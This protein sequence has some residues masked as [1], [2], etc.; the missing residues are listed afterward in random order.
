VNTPKYQIAYEMMKDGKTI[1]QIAAEMD[2]TLACV[3]D[4]MGRARRHEINRE[5]KEIEP[6]YM[7]AVKMTREGYSRKAIA[8][9]M[10]VSVW[11]VGCY[12]T[13]ARKRGI[14][15]M[16]DMSNLM[17]KSM[18]PKIAAWLKKQT[19]QDATVGDVILAIVTDAYLEECGE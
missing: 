11:N 8:E 10:Q 3:H 17:L 1:H 12:I 18:Q 2:V 19:P 13:Y 4:Y 9:H 5:E 7:I 14:S 6:K 16:P 15:V